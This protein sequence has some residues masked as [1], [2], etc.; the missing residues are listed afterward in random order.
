MK[1]ISRL[2]SKSAIQ[3]R[4]GTAHWAKGQLM[5]RLLK[6]ISFLTA[7]AEIAEGEIWIDQTGKVTFSKEIPTEIHQRIRNVISSH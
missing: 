7:E 5:N 6:D 3:I 4:G 1:F 2:F